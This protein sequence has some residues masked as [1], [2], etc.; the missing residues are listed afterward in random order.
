[1]TAGT[2]SA[3]CVAGLGKDYVVRGAQAHGTLYDVL[4]AGIRRPLGWLR[5]PSA[6]DEDRIWALRD[7][8]FHVQPGEVVGVVGRNG[9]GKSTLLKIL[10]RITAPSCGRAEVRGRLSSLLEV[11]TGFHHELSGR[12]NVYLNGAILGMSRAEIARRFDEIVQFAE[13]ERFV[14]VPV[15]HYSSGMYVRLAFAV[16]AHLETDVLLVDE[17]LAVGD[18]EFQRKSLGKMGEVARGGRT[19]LFVSHN[20]AAVR[21]LCER[22]LLLESGRLRFDGPTGEALAIYEGSFAEAGGQLSASHFSGELA[23]ELSFHEIRLLQDG[24][25]V[26]PVDPMRE[27]VV[28]LHG[29]AARGIPLL[30]MNLAIYREGFHVGSCFDTPG[31]APMRAGAFVARFRFPADVFR[32][33]RYTV[34]VGAS[35][36]ASWVWGPDVAVLDF[37]ENQGGRPEHRASGALQLPYS[38]E[39]VQ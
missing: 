33:G 23:A 7:I 29:T 13:I 28:E 6:R 17:V 12:E 2:S 20:L 24:Q 19:V 4:A 38:G 10:S 37:S 15:K 18:A 30:D 8:G 1:M 27:F 36:A 26:T 32:P 35:T 11:G 3:I 25:A 31:A 39:R 9:A 22:T 14:D 21:D 16:A 34:G 5:T